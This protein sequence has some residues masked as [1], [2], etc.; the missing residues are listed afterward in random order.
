[1]WLSWMK[2]VE[3]MKEELNGTEEKRKT[4]KIEEMKKKKK[5]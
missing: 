5:I 4:L 1:M 3:T 2:E